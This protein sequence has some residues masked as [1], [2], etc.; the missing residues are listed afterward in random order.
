MTPPSGRERCVLR[1]SA[2]VG[3]CS[4]LAFPHPSATAGISTTETNRNIWYVVF[5]SL[6]ISQELPGRKRTKERERER[7]LT[8]IPRA[9]DSSDSSLSKNRSFSNYWRIG[10]TKWN[11]SFKQQPWTLTT[12][13]CEIWMGDSKTVQV[14]I[15]WHPGVVRDPE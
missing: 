10:L 7:D 3:S 8:L 15:S 14:T 1:V 12:C 4:P 9:I 11:D 6:P 2:P 5:Q 13:L